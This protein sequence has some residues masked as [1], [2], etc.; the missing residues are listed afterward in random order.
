LTIPLGA[1]MLGWMDNSQLAL[2]STKTD[3]EGLTRAGKL[4]IITRKMHWLSEYRKCILSP[5]PA[6]ATTASRYTRYHKRSATGDGSQWLNGQKRI[7]LEMSNILQYYL[8][9]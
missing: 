2:V 8:W 7:F 5:L 3:G 9:R 6:T 4:D 1:K